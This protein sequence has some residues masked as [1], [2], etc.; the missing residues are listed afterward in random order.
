MLSIV[1][2]LYVSLVD[3]I[4]MLLKAGGRFNTMRRRGLDYIDTPLHTAVELE[5]LDAIKELLDAG[6]TVTCLNRAGQTPLHVCVK[7][8]LEEHLKVSF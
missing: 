7:K 2:I 3:V 4:R 8:E 1:L 5:S 6:A